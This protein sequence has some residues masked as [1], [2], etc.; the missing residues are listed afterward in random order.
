[1][2]GWEEDIRVWGWGVKVSYYLFICIL[3]LIQDFKLY[4]QCKNDPFCVL[5]LE[6]PGQGSAVTSVTHLMHR[7]SILTGVTV[8]HLCSTLTLS[9]ET[10]TQQLYSK[11]QQLYSW[12]IFP[13]VLGNITFFRPGKRGLCSICFFCSSKYH[14]AWHPHLSALPSSRRPLLSISL[15]I[16]A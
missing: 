10:K 7:L 6:Y 16:P 11:T 4:N 12:L 2:Y 13:L 9:Q 5:T 8:S 3:T 1:M 15:F 14:R